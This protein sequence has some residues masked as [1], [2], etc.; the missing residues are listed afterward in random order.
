MMIDPLIT[1]KILNMQILDV[2]GSSE[3]VGRLSISVKYRSNT[4]EDKIEDDIQ[5][6][7]KLYYD[8]FETDLDKIKEVIVY[9]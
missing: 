1:S 5:L 3:E 7:E 9:L 6:V 2:S 8:P 4:F